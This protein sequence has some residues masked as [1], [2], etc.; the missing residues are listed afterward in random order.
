MRK[1]HA[2]R[3]PVKHHGLDTLGTVYMARRSG[4]KKEDEPRL[5]RRVA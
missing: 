5:S 3:H 4:C 2:E 1:R